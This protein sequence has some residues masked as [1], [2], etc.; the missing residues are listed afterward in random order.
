MTNADKLNAA[1]SRAFFEELASLNVSLVT[2]TIVLSS[3]FLEH[4]DTFQATYLDDFTIGNRLIPRAMVQDTTRLSDLVHT[5]RTIAS[6][7]SAAVFVITAVNVS[8]ARVVI[9]ANM[10]SVL[11]A[12]RDFDRWPT[13]VT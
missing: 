1:L 9:D 11:P 4:Y 5:V 2:N 10:N 12:W 7:N 8:P 3:S 13:Q 6:S